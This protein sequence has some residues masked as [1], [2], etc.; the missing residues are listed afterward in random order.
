M[1]R[2]AQQALRLDELSN[3]L[4]ENLTLLGSPSA[5]KIEHYISIR[6]MTQRHLELGN[7]EIRLIQ[8]F[9]STARDLEV[10]SSIFESVLTGK[11][12]S[13]SFN[14]AEYLS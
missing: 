6:P 9:V 12:T 7:F 1:G 10:S 14:A 2:M 8:I 5:F 4:Y 3:S 13:F 11:V